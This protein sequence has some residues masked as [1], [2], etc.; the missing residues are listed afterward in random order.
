M[1]KLIDEQVEQRLTVC[2]RLLI[3]EQVL[4]FEATFRDEDLYEFTRYCDH[5]VPVLFVVNFGDE[6]SEKFLNCVSLCMQE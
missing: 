1:L 2:E 3:T 5:E 4:E 6:T